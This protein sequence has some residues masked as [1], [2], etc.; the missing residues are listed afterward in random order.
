MACCLGCQQDKF[1]V[2]ECQCGNTC[3]D[4]FDGKV[5]CDTCQ[6]NKIFH[7]KLNDKG[8]TANPKFL[9]KLVSHSLFQLYGSS[10]GFSS[11][12]ELHMKPVNDGM[13]TIDR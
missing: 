9:D 10:V 6:N 3:R 7:I 5:L 13:Y 4:C 8:Q 11:A 2:A 12:C 1:L